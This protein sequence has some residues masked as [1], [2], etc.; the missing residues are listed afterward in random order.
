MAEH[1][2]YKLR[3]VF[4][5]GE[6][7]DKIQAYG[8]RISSRR[9]RGMHVCTTDVISVCCPN[10]F[11]EIMQSAAS[12]MEAS[13]NL[14]DSDLRCKGYVCAEESVVRDGSGKEEYPD[15]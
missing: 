14:E 2:A 11:S 4:R 3:S 13:T 1:R 6:L 10:K 8:R 7:A 15:N 12:K 9:F 5:Y